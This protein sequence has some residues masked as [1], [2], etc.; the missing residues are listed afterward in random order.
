MPWALEDLAQWPFI[1]QGDRIE[2]DGFTLT[3]MVYVG[4]TGILHHDPHACCMEIMQMGLMLNNIIV[5]PQAPLVWG[6]LDLWPNEPAS[7]TG[8]LPLLPVHTSVSQY[9]LHYHFRFWTIFQMA[10]NLITSH[11]WTFW[12]GFQSHGGASTTMTLTPNTDHCH[13]SERLQLWLRFTSANSF[14][15]AHLLV[16]PT[17]K[18]CLSL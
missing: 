13:K 11:Y 7:L 4:L 9:L 15:M 3:G 14:A 18:P 12:A 2:C 1:I 8:C 5:M 10:V 16:T 6:P 17:T